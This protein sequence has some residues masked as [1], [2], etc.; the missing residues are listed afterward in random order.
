MTRTGIS[1]VWHDS[2]ERW[3]LRELPVP[4]VEPDG[5][6][7]RVR[8]TGLCGSDL[9]I[10]RN[11]GAA[12]NAPPRDP[13]VFGHEMMGE[14]AGLG[15]K[16]RTDSLQRPL[17][18][19]DRVVFPY[20]FPCMRCY[21]CIRG[22]MAACA[23]RLGRKPL[24]EW[25]VCNGGFAQYYYLRSTHFIFKAPDDLSN[26]ALAPLNCAMSQVM[27]ALH[28]GT[29]RMDDTIVVQGAGGLGIYATA[30]AAEQGARKVI[31]IDGQKPRLELAVRCGATD[32]ID[33]SEYPTAEA[34]IDRV[35]QLTNGIGADRVI[36]LVGFPNV[37]EEGVKMC[38]IRG[39]Y[40]EIG[41]IMPNSIP[42]IDMHEM[43]WKQIRLFAVQHYDPWIIPAA[44]N[45]ISRTR[46]RYPLADLVSHEF[47]LD[48]IAE[49]FETSEWV[50]RADGTAVTR[51][52]ITP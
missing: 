26:A 25:N 31:V 48:N 37:I 16:V 50:G 13:F 30:I 12:P 27:E 32:T 10:W 41:N 20:F 44:M 19:G 36:E 38:R 21:N 51:A 6:S 35:M 29:V 14:I 9:H 15:P 17:K 28:L 1:A 49:A 46:D 34:R 2:G 18:E 39:T 4:E 22:E 52:V 40:L 3:E 43:I 42:Q 8:A 5:I 24:S 11:D 23:Y 7:V 33:M 47:S 45:F